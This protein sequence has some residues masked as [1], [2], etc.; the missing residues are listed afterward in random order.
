[1][2]DLPNA[3]IQRIAKKTGAERI[4][5]DATE[6]LAKKAEN[7]IANLVKKANAYA[8][9]AGRKTLKAEDIELADGGEAPV[10]PPVKP[11]V[12]PSV[13]PPAK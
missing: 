7:Y 1:M 5:T 10:K 11:K 2:S 13:N 12:K 9:H 6:L 8:I 4:G 3:A